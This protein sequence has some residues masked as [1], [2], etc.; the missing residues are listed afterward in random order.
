M[1]LERITSLIKDVRA[2]GG[3]PLIALE[4]RIAEQELLL[5]LMQMMRE[6]LKETAPNITASVKPKPASHLR[7]QKKGMV[8]SNRDVL[9]R[10]IAKNGPQTLE[11]LRDEDLIPYGSVVYTLNDPKWFVQ[12]KDFRW[13]LTEE[14]CQLLADEEES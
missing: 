3:D 1:N 8:G 5:E 7:K 10:Y 14:V 4:L 6:F 11:D 13:A 2:A 9:A 12:E